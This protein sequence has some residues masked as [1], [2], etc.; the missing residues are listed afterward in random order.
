MS[1]E[2]RIISSQLLIR[3]QQ[4]MTTSVY[5]LNSALARHIDAR[6]DA[7]ANSQAHM[8]IY[9]ALENW[10]LDLQDLL[11]RFHETIIQDGMMH[12]I[13]LAGRKNEQLEFLL[14]FIRPELRVYSREQAQLIEGFLR[15][16]ISTEL[17]SGETPMQVRQNIIRILTTR[18]YALRIAGTEAHTALERGAWEA[19]NS[20]GVRMG[21]SWVSREDILVRSAHA[22]AHGQTKEINQP[23][24]VGGELMM[25]PGVSTA[26]AK[27]RV[28]CRCT[29]NYMLI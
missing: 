29:V 7:Q 26:S 13:R 22:A 24:T 27:N 11:Y 4:R 12:V 9:L 17:A 3:H 15:A 19:A 14:N 5:R 23:F 10:R 18:N 16:R 8:M 28:H 6:W 25:Y 1:L 2:E 21:K 20:L